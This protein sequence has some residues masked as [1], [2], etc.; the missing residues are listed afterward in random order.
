MPIVNL[1]HVIETDAVERARQELPLDGPY[2]FRV[3]IWP[4]QIVILRVVGKTAEQ[5]SAP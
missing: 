5:R 4:H 1:A 3:M 2:A